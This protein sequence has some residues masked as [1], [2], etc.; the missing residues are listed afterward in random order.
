VS[1][2]FDAVVIGAGAF[3]ASTAYHLAQ[4]GQTVALLDRFALGSQT[5]PRAAGL[6][7][8]IRAKPDMTRIAMLSVEKIRRFA[9]ETGQPLV[10]HEGGSAKLARTA[11]DAE[12]IR[13]EVA[14]G[15]ALGLAIDHIDEA[16]LTRLA[17]F[18][19]PVGVEAMWFTASD[20]YLQPAQL[21]IGYA[22]AAQALGAET[23]PFAPVTAI[24]RQN[25]AV[26]GVVAAGERLHAPVVVDAAGAWARLV[27]AEAGVRIAIQPVRHQLMVTAPIVGVADGQPI[28]RVID[29]NVY[30]RPDGGGLLLGGYEPD[31]LPVAPGELAAGFQIADLPLD[32]GVVRRLAASVAEIFP[33]I[34]AAPVRELRGGLPT[35]TADDRPLVGPV[36]GLAG[37]YAITGC[38]VG[39]LSAAP[40]L[41]QLLAEQIVHGAPSLPLDGLAVDRFGPEL[42]GDDAVRAAGLWAYSHHYAV[43][44]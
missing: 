1:R 5:S 34:P 39:G 32:P 22:R 7:Q 18:A 25:G 24:E 6:T 19:R 28:C 17:P 16:D 41:G 43:A 3:G 14:A 42:D 35:M 33:A 37:F 2:D 11:A 13:A 21:P 38:C 4:L 31:P 40:G 30:V 15:Q 29:V 23:R 9:E 10:Y 27:A 36:P 44:G 12:Q 26:V 20:L 8:Q